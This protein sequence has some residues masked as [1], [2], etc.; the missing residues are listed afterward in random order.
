LPEP[1]CAV[2]TADS[3]TIVR[4]FAEE[5]VYCPRKILIRSATH[6]LKQ[7]DASS[8][9]NVNTPGDL[10]DSVLKAAS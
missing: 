8:L 5:G 9:D 4:Q 3:Q 2:Y 7:V 1:L 10:A 6:L